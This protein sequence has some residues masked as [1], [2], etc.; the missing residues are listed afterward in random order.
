MFLFLLR[1][2]KNKACYILLVLVLIFL[3]SFRGLSVGTDTVNY[4]EIF[5]SCTDLLS[6]AIRGYEILLYFIYYII[7]SFDGTYQTALFIQTILFLL[8]LSYVFYKKFS[9]PIIPLFFLF[10]LNFYLSEFNISRQMIAVSFI[11]LSAYFYENKKYVFTAIPF[12]LACLLHNSA[13]IALLIFPLSFITLNKS[14]ILLAVIASLILPLAIDFSSLFSTVVGSVE[15]ISY[16]ESYIDG[17]IGGRFSLFNIANTLLYIYIIYKNPVEISKLPMKVCVLGLILSNIFVF[18]PSRFTRLMLY[19]TVFQVFAFTDLVYK[20]NGQDRVLYLY[21]ILY[22]IYYVCI[23]N[24][25]EVVPY[26]LAKN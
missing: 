9:K 1:N 16:Y 26:M 19:F 22:F 13:I 15:S 6:I 24:Y 18:A 11:V 2:T 12:V 21:S 5:Y 14:Y 25:N 20:K 23:L 3:S 7:H 8:P 17:G 4:E 10:A